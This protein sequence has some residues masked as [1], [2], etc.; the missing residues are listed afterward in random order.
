MAIAKK[1]PGALAKSAR[2]WLLA[3]AA[4]PLILVAQAAECPHGPEL[5]SPGAYLLTWEPK[6]PGIYDPTG[7]G[8]YPFGGD[9]LPDYGLRQFQYGPRLPQTPK[10]RMEYPY[11]DT[12]PVYRGPVDV[13]GRNFSSSSGW[14]IAMA[15]DTSSRMA[16]WR[17]GRR[18][19]F[20]S[21]T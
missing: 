15:G 19:V 6:M 10:P 14:G 9:A 17:Q 20:P 3:A 8:I 2:T 13:P 5:A 12:S 16:H 11:E 1:F 7:S 18:V 4:W 21:T